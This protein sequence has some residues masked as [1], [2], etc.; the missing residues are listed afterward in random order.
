LRTKQIFC[1]LIICFVLV[2]LRSFAAPSDQTKS[3]EAKN[4]AA[5]VEKAATLVQTEGKDA[6]SAF[7]K[8]DGDWWKGDLYIFVDGMD[9]T[10]LVHPPDP[11]IEGQNLL[12][13]PT[14]KAVAESLIQTAEKGSGWA[15]YMWPKPG[16]ST[17]S[18]KISYVKK[19]TMPDKTVVIVGAGMYVKQ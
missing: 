19:V 11:K 5:F 9:G 8:K 18:K 3:E 7:R 10:V 14:A 15:E 12:K 16:E 4:L 13:D 17:P 6:F 1:T 2:C